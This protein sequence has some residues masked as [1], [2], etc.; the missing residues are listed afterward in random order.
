MHVVGHE[1]E[2]MNI[3]FVD[4]ASFAEVLQENAAVAVVEEARPA[5]VP[6]RDQMLRET[7][8]VDS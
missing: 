4:R 2:R 6:P 7:W 3:A 1:H 8:N 5:I